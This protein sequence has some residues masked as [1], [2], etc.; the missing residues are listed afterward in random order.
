MRILCDV[1]LAELAR[2]LRCA[3]HDTILAG[4]RDLDG[5][6][7]AR[8]A[9]EG[10]ALFTRDR[11]LARVGR[12][13]KWRIPVVLVEHAPLDVLAP[14]LA[15]EHGVDWDHAPFT[16]CV[17]DNALLVAASEADLDR[18]PQQSR[19]MPGPFSACPQC[20]R[21]YWPGSHF[22]RMRARLDQWV[23][24]RALLG[25]NRRFVDKASASLSVELLRPGAGHNPDPG[26][27]E[28]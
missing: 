2:W 4:R 25:E 6:I 18:M 21:V 22:R 20:R 17:L 7:L 10:R 19:A 27:N 16:R 14:L 8:C 3:G 9:G 11:A 15:A 1:M 26:R 5:A 24:P 13:P 23:V 28:P 12:L